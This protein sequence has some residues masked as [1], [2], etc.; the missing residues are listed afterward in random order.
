MTEIVRPEPDERPWGRSRR[1]SRRQGL[2]AVAAELLE[3]PTT[4]RQDANAPTA[5]QRPR[6]HL[7]ASMLVIGEMGLE[8]MNRASASLGLR[9][10][11]IGYRP[12]IL[13]LTQPHAELRRG[14]GTLRMGHQRPNQV[15]PIETPPAG[16]PAA[17]LLA[18]RPCY[19]ATLA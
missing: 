6:E 18:P 2:E 17:H 5:N 16:S 15:S 4:L 13:L 7:N 9:P 1:R 14:L 11:S 19:S 12:G 10:V 3:E 8:P